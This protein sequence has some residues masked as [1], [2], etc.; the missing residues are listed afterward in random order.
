[1]TDDELAAASV[2]LGWLFRRRDLSGL[3]PQHLEFFKARYS[4]EDRRRI[5]GAITRV[6]ARP[7]VDIT[8][9][10]PGMPYTND[11]LQ[12][13]LAAVRDAIKPIV[14]GADGK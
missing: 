14:E 4:E 5:Y 7:E 9:L 13:Y 10:V 2:P 8:A 6:L 12:Q 11:Q 1:M 3:T